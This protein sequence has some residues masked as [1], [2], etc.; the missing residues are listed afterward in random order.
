LDGKELKE[1]KP[2][3]DLGQEIENNHFSKGIWDLKDS[4]PTAACFKLS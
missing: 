3:G 4:H 1:H 2:V